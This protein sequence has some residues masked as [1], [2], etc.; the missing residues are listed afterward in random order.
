[1]NDST[2]SKRVRQHPRAK[3]IQRHQDQPLLWPERV[4]PVFT[5]R[6][7]RV[8]V[9]Q[10]GKITPYGGVS[11]VHDLAMRLQLDR[12]INRSIRLLKINVPYFESDHILT[13]VYNQY[14][15]GH[16][17]EDIANLQHSDAV[18]HL[19]GACRIP[20]PTTAG[21]FL[22][23][24]GEY[25]LQQLQQVI[26]RARERVWRKIPRS[27][28]KVATVDLDSTIKEVYGQ[29]KQGADFSYNGQWSYHPLLATLAETHE[30][31]RTVNRPG[32]R[33]SPEGAAAVLHEV[34]P[35]VGRHFGKVF[36][37]GDSKFYQ[38]AIIAECERY[39]ASFAFVMDGYA[40]LHEIADSLPP[41]AWK[42]FSAHRAEQV[43]Q[44][45]AD[46]K[47]RRKRR[48]LRARRAKER[49]YQTLVTTRQWVA[50]FD[51]TM[52]RG[53]KDRDEGLAG[54]TYRVVVKRQQVNISEGQNHLFT[55]YRDRFVITDIPN[56]HMDAGE[57]FCFAYGRCDQENII[58]Q[59]K[60]GIAAMRMPTG[61]LLANGAF[62]MAGQLAWCLRS[63]LS[64]LALPQETTR[65]EWKWFRQAFVYIAAKITY[66]ARRAKVYL[67]GS[68][69]FVEHLV[70]A[71]QRLHTF[72]FQ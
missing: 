45:A 22:R 48:R 55:E 20:D 46:K 49:G 42:P 67:A 23:R 52:P 12:D 66:S 18:K 70:I 15:G 34:L 19:L 21:D 44:A 37:R 53:G 50:E 33:P 29:C 2:R 28:R 25:H 57:V 8:Q 1:V 71:S 13:H 35:M 47:T 40:N 56:S 26:D 31:L 32:N 7:V 14:V 63:W 64:A 38:R 4:G 39:G 61:E 11:L 10:R 60:N 58:E 65:W 9:Q 72:A 6:R 3:K 16:C 36:V 59:F 41:S 24:F 69:R 17:I 68:H 54:K 43:A 62:L 27:R 5:N 51:Y 30:P